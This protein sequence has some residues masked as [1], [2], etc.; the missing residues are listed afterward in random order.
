MST[1]LS[2]WNQNYA[3][4]QTYNT[5]VSGHQ[6]TN[7]L[8][9]IER[10]GILND[11]NPKVAVLMVGGN[12]LQAGSQANQVIANIARIIELIRG[13]LPH[14]RIL[15]LG[16]LPAGGKP[17]ELIEQ[18]K[19]INAALAL[20]ENQD[21]IR[22]LDMLAEFADENENIHRE[23]YQADQTH[24]TLL[25]YEL[26]QRTMDPLFQELLMFK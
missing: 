6:S 17:D 9:L 26:W 19:L 25:G 11:I 14:A 20:M 12:D 18:G 5:A 7:T 21:D 13:K 24:L 22:Y 2:V 1:G 16:L 8:D 3:F 23:L 4:L 15:L 10:V